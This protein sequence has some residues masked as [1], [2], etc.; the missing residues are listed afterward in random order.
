M[1]EQDK[2][3]ERLKKLLVLAERGATEGERSAAM[4]RAQEIA[5]KYAIDLTAVNQRD[6][7]AA[8]TYSLL[9]AMAFPDDSWKAVIGLA[10]ARLYA[11]ELVLHSSPSSG[12]RE[13]E[14]YIYGRPSS[15][16]VV[17]LFYSYLINEAKR[18]NREAV[19]KLKLDRAGRLQFRRS[20]RIYCASALAKR[21]Q[22]KI[23]E[24]RQRGVSDGESS[25]RALV[26]AT[27]YDQERALVEEAMKD[28]NAKSRDLRSHSA[29]DVTGI[30]AGTAAGQSISL[31]DQIGGGHGKA[32]GAVDAQARLPRARD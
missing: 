3:T 25:S 29:K 32:T 24:M 14:A 11:C 17:R 7:P 19:S 22:D 6:T 10:V 1:T 23:E 30:L 18:Q 5:L 15:I 4:A 16:N 28:V 13:G 9:E 31:H 12:G 26:V 8:V 27:W 20:F 2:V 21:I